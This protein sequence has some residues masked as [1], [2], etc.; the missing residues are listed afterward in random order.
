MPHIVTYAAFYLIPLNPELARKT[1]EVL[2]NGPSGEVRFN[3]EMTLKEWKAGRLD[4]EWF[5]KD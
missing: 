3:A 5:M 4:P 2:S 1:F